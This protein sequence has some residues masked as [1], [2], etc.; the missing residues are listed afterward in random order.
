VT[1]AEVRP[2][3]VAA[4]GPSVDDALV[5]R[6][7]AGIAAGAR[8]EREPDLAPF[9]GRPLA[10]LPVSTPADVAAAVAAARDAQR[11]WAAR[12]VA[13][14]ARV[15][16]RLHDLVLERQS[17][18]AD[19]VQAESGKAR[20]D[21]F[22]E[23]ADVALAARYA[24]EA[25]PRLLRP[26]RRRGLV[27]GVTLAYE[28]RHPKGV[29]GVISP[30]NYP[31]TLAVSDALPA[32]VA[33]NA[34]VAKPDT[35]CALTALLGRALA[36]EAGLPEGLWQIVVGDGPTVGG[37]VVDSADY[38]SFTG[39]TRTG[40]AV[41]RRAGER[42]VGASLELGGKNPLLVLADADLDRA[43]EGAVRACFSNAGQLCVATERL[44]V[45][46]SVRAA[47][48]ERFLQRVRALRLGASFDYGYDVGTLVSPAQLD[49]VARHVDDAVAKGATVLAGGRARP[50]VAPWSYEPTVLTGVRPGMLAADEETF[51]PVVSVYSFTGEDEAVAAA[52]ET[53][54]GLNASIWTR[55]RRRGVRLATR[56]RY[57]SV[58][59][60]EAYG[61]VWGS[62]DLPLG[63]MGDSGLG[64]RHG[65]EGVLRY[66]E[67]QGV[68]VQRLLGIRPL[69]GSSHEAFARQMTA[70]LRA[71]QRTGRP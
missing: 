39:S 6:L 5:R 34:V 63:G 32:F 12:P 4:P 71:L 1:P 10:E 46:E 47:F 48:L 37:A 27:P 23:I 29:V 2:A 52:N 36:V 21:A 30:W 42:L 38:V 54:Y 25:G 43:A 69:R 20:R 18:I 51:G 45:A 35:Q 14:R 16:G 67:A 11:S 8:A 58:N 13:D 64:R 28:V 22:E 62:H 50:D 68:A 15:V 3:A 56:L 60:N 9:T 24:A 33:G 49:K 26:A 7:V 59:V 57:G 40:R 55:D 31:F 61:A 66:T 41:A 17:Q 53:P 44:Y 70:L 19:L 65:R